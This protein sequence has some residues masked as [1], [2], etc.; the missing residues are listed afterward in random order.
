ML[1][2][3]GTSFQRKRLTSAITNKE[4]RILF[5]TLRSH[6]IS[7]KITDSWYASTVSG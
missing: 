5:Q 1:Q 2:F 3:S 6:E 4:K 7:S